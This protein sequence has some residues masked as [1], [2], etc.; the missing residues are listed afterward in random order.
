MLKKHIFNKITF[1]AG[2]LAIILALFACSTSQ[3]TETKPE[4][5]D[6]RVLE[7]ETTAPVEFSEG[8]AKPEEIVK[9]NKRF[10]EK[11]N[12]LSL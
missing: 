3:K 1:T 11:F 5:T 12:F 7:I 9:E 6:N 10:E 2:S 4:N 8:T